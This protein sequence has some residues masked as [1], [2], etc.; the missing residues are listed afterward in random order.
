VRDVCGD[1][2][3]ARRHQEEMLGIAGE[4]GTVLWLIE[5]RTNLAELRLLEGD[6]DGA[7]ALLAQAIE[8]GG[9]AV[10]FVVQAVR[11][12]GEAELR[13]G[14]A[15]AALATVR[16]FDH[17]GSSYRVL[18]LDARRIEPEA[19]ML[20]GDTP[21]AEALLGQVAHDAAA[22]GARP[23]GW[24][25]GLALAELL[26]RA[27]GAGGRP[28]RGLVTSK[29]GGERGGVRN[30]RNGLGFVIPQKS[31]ADQAR[32]LAPACWRSRCCAGRRRR[33][34]CKSAENSSTS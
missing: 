2:G 16:Q 20:G 9:D 34:T 18:A 5:A 1:L 29:S 22:L 4:L 13:R 10:V 11:L 17:M 15:D 24:R 19:L 8:I 28:P 21:R 26:G 33:A 12:E 14:Q 31:H 23:A 7:A 27:R 3:G 32:A 6:L 25:A 30:F